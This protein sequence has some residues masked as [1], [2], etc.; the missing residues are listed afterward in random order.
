[1]S[2]IGE[3]I[4]E[5]IGE[6]IDHLTHPKQNFVPNSNS[7]T[8][9]N[10]S[11]SDNTDSNNNDNDQTVTIQTH[12]K[13]FHA[14]DVA[15]ASL[16]SGYYAQK[17]MKVQLIRSRNKELLQSSDI[18]I[19][20]GGVYDPSTHRYDHHQ[21]SC[22]EVFQEGFNIPL[23]SVGMVWK[24]FGK[25]ILEM[26]IQHNKQFKHCDN[27]QEHIDNLWVDV[28]VKAILEIDAHDNGVIP[29]EGGTRNYWPNLTVGNIIS[30]YNSPDVTNENIQTKAFR[31]AVNF[32]GSVFDVVLNDIIRK[33]FEFI[34]SY[35]IVKRYIEEAP[36]NS[37]YL[38]VTETIPSIYK[39]LN[40]LDPDCQYKFLI[41]HNEGEKEITIKTRGRKDDIMTPI[42]PLLSEVIIRNNLGPERLDQLI[43]VHKNLFIAKTTTIE[44]AIDIVG[45]S[46]TWAPTVNDYYMS[47][48]NSDCNS[49]TGPEYSNISLTWN[50]LGSTSKW[51]IGCS[52]GLVGVGL[53]SIGL[54]GIMSRYEE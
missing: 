15:A 25:E 51:I 18:L 44:A 42:V 49:Y 17:N 41:F 21:K 45:W 48:C 32:F 38:I 53:I 27:Y 7:D 39:C 3:D 50:K 29:V 40:K 35:E 22:N 31:N 33:Y 10:D 34:A 16:L 30:F 6:D 2:D 54:D 1:M 46:L 47:D 4:G 52:L 23:S 28:Y 37:E 8:D 5:E 9:S 24:H 26:Y 13:K 12:D 14:D 43:F 20:V 11:G 36:E 19:D